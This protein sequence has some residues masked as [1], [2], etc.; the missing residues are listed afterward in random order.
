MEC[1]SLGGEIYFSTIT[2]RDSVH[3]SGATAQREESIH[4]T[5]IRKLVTKGESAKHGTIG[6]GP[7]S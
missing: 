6:Q 7:P 4:A 5:T 1:L 3:S 2:H